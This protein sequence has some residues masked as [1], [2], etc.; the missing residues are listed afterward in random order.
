MPN[1]L[2]TTRVTTHTRFALLALGA[3]SLSGL[4][5]PALAGEAPDGGTY[6]A[7]NC[8]DAVNHKCLTKPRDDQTSRNQD[9]RDQARAAQASRE[10]AATA[11][12]EQGADVHSAVGIPHFN[13]KGQVTSIDYPTLGYSEKTVGDDAIVRVFPNGRQ[14][15]VYLGGI[16]NLGTTLHGGPGGNGG[17]AGSK[18]AR[19]APPTTTRTSATSTM[20]KNTATPTPT[21]STTFDKATNTTTRDHRTGATAAPAASKPDTTQFATQPGAV[22]DHRHN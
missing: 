17:A 2:R 21:I 5:L 9:S 13:G 16:H 7:S 10:A 14:Q 6:N 11:R 18:G 15:L 3:I 22:R 20:P 4:T 19:I 8:R 1:T 12:A